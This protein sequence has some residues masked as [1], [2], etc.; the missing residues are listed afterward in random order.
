MSIAPVPSD[1]IPVATARVQRAIATDEAHIPALNRIPSLDGLR[2]AS[3]LLVFVAHAGLDTVVP[4]GLGVTIFFFLSGFLITTLLRSEFDKS[5]MVNLRHFWLRRAL[6][7][8]PPFYIVFAAAAIAAVLL[9]P[10]SLAWKAIAAQVFHFTNYWIIWH[11]YEGQPI[12]TGV[13]WSLAVEEH[14][15][16]LFPFVFIAMRKLNFQNRSQALILWGTCLLVL[17]WRCVLVLQFDAPTNRTYMATDT[18]VD[19]ILFGCALAVWNNPI[20]DAGAY[21]GKLWQKLL[22]PVGGA[23]LLGSLLFRDPVFRETIRYSLQG[24]ALTAIFFAAIQLYRYPPFSWL[25]ARPLVLIG[26]LSYSIYLVHLTAIFILQRL[27]PSMSKLLLGA[28]A[29]GISFAIAWAIHR[30]IEQPCAKLRR[31]LTST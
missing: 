14:F 5:G 29:F 23:L 4:G 6:R 28:I 27:Y 1:A 30:L 22:A 19:S 7:I 17:L 20:R 8:L 26:E 11:G 21:S 18:R 24:I 9:E 12:G 31:A 10:G 16:L 13:Y 25:N 3:I 15:Y 2:A